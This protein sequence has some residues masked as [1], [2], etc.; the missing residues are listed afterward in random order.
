MEGALQGIKIKINSEKRKLFLF[1][2]CGLFGSVSY[3]D[4]FKE[5]HRDAN[6]GHLVRT[7]HRL[8]FPPFNQPFVFLI[9]IRIIN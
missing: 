2:I 3:D 5:D 4:P 7:H 6:L 8:Q 9:F 1:N